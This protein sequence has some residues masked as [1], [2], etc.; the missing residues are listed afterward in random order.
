MEL[1]LQTL[2]C[3]LPSVCFF[4]LVPPTVEGGDETS[5]LI[6]MANNLLELDCQVTGSPPPTLM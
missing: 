2:L 5:Y 6:V 4:F 3:Q 1:F